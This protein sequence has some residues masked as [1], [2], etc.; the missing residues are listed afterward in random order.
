MKLLNRA[1]TAAFIFG[2]SAALPAQ[3]AV[4]ISGSTDGCFGSSCVAAASSSVGR[5]TFND[6]AFG[7]ITLNNQLNVT[8]GSFTFLTGQF[9]TYNTAFTLTLDF[10]APAGILPD[11]S[12][13][14][15]T[16]QGTTSAGNNGTVVIDFSN[17]PTV[18]SFNGGSISL[19]V[20]DVEIGPGTT[21]D[22]VG[23][24]TLA[25]AVPEPSTWAMMIFGFAGVAFMAYRRRKTAALCEA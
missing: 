13:F 14:S 10:T 6:A 22:I 20:N 4:V 25:S 23:Q 16:V 12:N 5:L 18:F 15:A 2:V 21:R 7:P 1:L 9:Q 11:P 3:A 17:A 19:L 24:F 8:L